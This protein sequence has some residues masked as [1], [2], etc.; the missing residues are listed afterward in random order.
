MWLRGIAAL[1][2]VYLGSVELQK[3]RRGAFD[4]L[5]G[6]RLTLRSRANGQAMVGL[7]LALA[8]LNFWRSTWSLVLAS[9]SRLAALPSEFDGP[10]KLTAI[11]GVRL[12]RSSPRHI[13]I[14]HD[15]QPL[16][17]NPKYP[18]NCLFGLQTRMW[19]DST[20]RRTATKKSTEIWVWRSPR[21]LRKWLPARP[22]LCS[23]PPRGPRSR[24]AQTTTS[25]HRQFSLPGIL[26]SELPATPPPP[27]PPPPS[28][29]LMS[30]MTRK[31][32]SNI[33]PCMHACMPLEVLHPTLP[34]EQTRKPSTRRRRRG[35]LNHCCCCCCCSCSLLSW[36]DRSPAG[37]TLLTPSSLR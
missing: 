12:S 24:S 23:A 7:T 25:P 36:P 4:L 17:N 29:A 8:Q 28:P 11:A 19:T 27:P 30:M 14:L 32:P 20:A 37:P 18:V 5:N 2:T 15:R 35:T 6:R 31:K 3:L 16:R 33:R 9:I 10:V 26:A 21:G 1:E 22:R 34:L 13:R